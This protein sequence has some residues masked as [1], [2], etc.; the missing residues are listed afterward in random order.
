MRLSIVRA[1]DVP[2]SDLNGSSDPFVK[3][4]YGLKEVG[5]TPFLRRTLGPEWNHE[6]TITL[7]ATQMFVVL[8]LWDRDDLSLDDLLGKCRIR[9]QELAE[10]GRR[11]PLSSM[12]QTHSLFFIPS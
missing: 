7:D 11:R 1:V 10:A 3:V 5:S 8:E 2:A 9:L 4:F 6:L 12:K